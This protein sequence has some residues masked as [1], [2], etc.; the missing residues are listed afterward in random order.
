MNDGGKKGGGWIRWNLTT[1]NFRGLTTEADQEGVAYTMERQNIDIICGQETWL[2]DTTKERWDTGELMINFGKDFGKDATGNV[3]T[4]G[5]AE[6]VCFILNKKMAKAFEE[7]GK[8]VKKYC[9]RLASM[10]IPLSNQTLYIINAYAPDSGQSKAKREGFQRRL[11]C[12]LAN[13]KADETLVLAGDFNGS[14]G[15]AE[16][17]SDGVSGTCGL[18]HKNEAGRTLNFESN[19]CHA[20]IGGPSVDGG[21]EIL[22]DVDA[23]TIKKVV[24]IRP[25]ICTPGRRPQSSQVHKC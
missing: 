18:P 21:A 15:V 8:R 13:C 2:A 5:R 14:M 11:E 20:W 6:G 19:R 22:W 10:R 4:K 7:G 25:H 23:C 1:Q 24:S 16:N 17:Q 12:A 3:N 9:S